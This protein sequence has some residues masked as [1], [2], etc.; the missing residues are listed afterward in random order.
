MH[1]GP[2]SS[3]EIHLVELYKS[4]AGRSPN[5]KYFVTRRLYIMFLPGRRNARPYNLAGHPA[6]VRLPRHPPYVYIISR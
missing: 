1:A 4:V 2:H 5:L 6:T 3:E